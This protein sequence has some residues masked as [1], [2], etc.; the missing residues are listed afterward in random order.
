MYYCQTWQ[1]WVPVEGSNGRREECLSLLFPELLDLSV[2]EFWTRWPDPVGLTKFFTASLIRILENSKIDTTFQLVL[3][4]YNHMTIHMIRN[5]Q[6]G[7]LLDRSAL[8]W[9]FLNLALPFW[10]LG[11]KFINAL[12]I[13]HLDYCNLYLAGLLLVYP[14]IFTSIQ[15]SAGKDLLVAQITLFHLLNVLHWLRVSSCIQHNILVHIS[16]APPLS[17]SFPDTLQLV[18]FALP[19]PPPSA[20]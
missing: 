5:N 19:T 12:V 3:L 2:T 11:R 14:S 1:Q 18:T 4:R 10:T 7:F 8:G 17:I 16:R 9:L 13:S 6:S 20:I 15:H